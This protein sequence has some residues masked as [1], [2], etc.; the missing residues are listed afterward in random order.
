M[1]EF[2][3]NRLQKLNKIEVNLPAVLE[4]LQDCEDQVEKE[5]GLLKHVLCL[6]AEE[7]QFEFL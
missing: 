7:K 5:I 1:K 4:E 3:N 2:K 6:E